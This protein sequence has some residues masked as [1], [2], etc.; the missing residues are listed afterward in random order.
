MKHILDKSFK[1]R[2]SF[3]TDIRKKFE[4]VRKR[5]EAEKKRSEAILAEADAKV[6]QIK[7]HLKARL[8]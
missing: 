5:L 1:Y 4:E 7:P 6:E 2:P 8:A 3:N